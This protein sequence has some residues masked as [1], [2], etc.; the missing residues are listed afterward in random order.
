MEK[1]IAKREYNKISYDDNCTFLPITQSSNRS[2]EI[3]DR[4]LHDA[5]PKNYDI[6]Y[7]I[8]FCRILI[9]KIDRYKINPRDLPL[10]LTHSLKRFLAYLEVEKDQMK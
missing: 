10:T 1:K 3:Q 2:D 7:V 6:N 4:G 8:S 9:D 5:L